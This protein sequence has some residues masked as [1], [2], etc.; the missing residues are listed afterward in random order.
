MSDMSRPLP[1]PIAPDHELH[2]PLLVAQ[3]A[4]GDPLEVDDAAKAELWTTTCGACAALA[5]DLRAVSIA[6]AWEPTPA[7]RRDYRIS[8]RQARELRGGIVQRLWR[9]LALPQSTMLRPAAAGVMSIGL[10][11]AVAASAW[12]GDGL[13]VP[14]GSEAGVAPSPVA[15]GQEVADGDG[16]T[17]RAAASPVAPAAGMLEVREPVTDDAGAER[18]EP[19]TNARK[20]ETLADPDEEAAAPDRPAEPIG[21]ALEADRVEAEGAPVAEQDLLAQTESLDEITLDS[22]AADDSIA[23]GADPTGARSRAEPSE[24]K[25]GT[26]DEAAT[27][28]ADAG[29]GANDRRAEL[30]TVEQATDL[31]SLV[32]VLGVVL[33]LGGAALLLLVWLARRRS[34]PLLR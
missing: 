27:M 30:A 11:M 24:P 3:H 6:V 4:A 20:S 10:L 13:A 32:L 15:A 2:D 21:S 19:A 1:L 12:P 29:T 22:A 8:P 7:R 34:D 9:G 18:P 33:A 23:P 17:F 25:A 31:R 16:S 28:V 14:S 5:A 26:A